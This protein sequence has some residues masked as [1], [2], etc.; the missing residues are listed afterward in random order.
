M[1]SDMGKLAVPLLLLAGSAF[2][3]TPDE[4]AIQNTFVKPWIEALR[5]QDKARMV[6]FLHPAVRTCMDDPSTKDYWDYVLDMQVHTAP[7]GAYIITRLRPM[8]GPVP[9]FM[10]EEDAAYPVRPTYEL[11]IDFEQS[12]LLLVQFLA[13]V[14]GTWYDLV[15]CP[16]EKGMAYF[17]RQMVE[18][19]QQKKRA[20]EL[21]AELKDPLRSQLNDL[22]R[23]QQK[24]DAIHKY[25]AAAGVDLTTAVGVINALQEAGR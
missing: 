5:S 12:N 6:S 13:P 2:G 22:L 18:G 17:R 24:I 4:A 7:A 16:N 19:A 25:Q 10:P 3:A 15:P 11:Q 9:T 14:N 20:A 8:Q 23:Q 21:L 1:V